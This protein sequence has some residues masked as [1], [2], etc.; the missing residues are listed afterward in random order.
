MVAIRAL[1]FDVDVRQVDRGLLV[2]EGFW[3]LIVGGAS[4]LWALVY[5]RVSL[6]L[7]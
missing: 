7:V 3:L 2:L 4:G 1:G 5:C 6:D